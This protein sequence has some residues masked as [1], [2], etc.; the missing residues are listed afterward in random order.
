M[1]GRFGAVLTAMLTPFDA[2]GALD[3]DAAQQVARWLVEQGNDGLVIAGT[4]GESPTLTDPE[5]LDLIKAVAEAVTVPVVA[6]TGTNDTAHSVG[7]TRQA[8]GLGA[9]G[10]LIVGP[11]YNRP[12]QAGIEAHVRACAAATELPVV[13][14]DV[15]G[16]TGKRLATDVLL[17]LFREVPNVVAFKDATGDLAAAAGL[18]HALGDGI[19]IYS[20]DDAATLPLLAVGAV[21][22]IGVATHW[23]TPQTVEMVAAHTKGDV[24]RARE[25]NG[26]MLESYAFGNTEESNYSMTAKAMLRTLGLPAGECRLPLPPT[27]PGVED[28]CR[29]VYSSLNA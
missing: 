23:C 10:V 11:Y 1:S 16:R 19:E 7:L 13:V 26:S 20:G 4:T 18:V 25:L 29:E 12:P 3:L 17:R 22:T 2:A 28:R 8:V 5:R 9:A 21:G 15:P 24:V 14:Y 27:P 6:G